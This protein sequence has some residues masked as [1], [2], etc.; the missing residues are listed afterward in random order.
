MIK[1]RENN[2]RGPTD[3]GWLKS[4]HTFSFG[5]YYDPAFIGF[6]HLR[7]INEDIVAPAAGFATHPHDNMEIVS[8]V[9]E[10]ALEHKD[11]LGTG[12]VIRPGEIQRMSAGTGVTHSEYNH[13]KDRSVH[14]L[15]IWFLPQEK[16]IAP[17]YE[18]KSFDD[19]S[20]RGQLKLVMSRTG[21]DGSLKINQDV[22]MYVSLL[23]E[24]HSLEH[25]L[26]E[27]RMQWLQVAR[28]AVEVNDYRLKAGDGASIIQEPLLKLERAKNAE[29]IL[30][31][32][33]ATP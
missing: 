7:V 10:G 22:D 16:N 12:S 17:S 21:R 25:K 30:M 33:L 29:I 8:Y 19:V 26:E 13:A 31:D 5:H 14:F 23:D 2:K 32:I 24:N 18:Q 4:M 27:G 6:G 15:Q 20:K 1:I 11:S 3:L 9:L 28:G